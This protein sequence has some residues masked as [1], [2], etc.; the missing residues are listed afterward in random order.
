MLTYCA[1]SGVSAQTALDSFEVFLGHEIAEHDEGGILQLSHQSVGSAEGCAQACLT[2]KGCNSFEYGISGEAVGS[3]RLSYD[4]R[5]TTAA[6]EYVSTPLWNYY[7]LSTP[8][9]V[10]GAFL[11]PQN[12]TWLPGADD[13]ATYNNVT[14]QACAGLCLHNAACRRYGHPHRICA[15]S[16]P[17]AFPTICEFYLTQ[18]NN[19]FLNAGIRINLLI[20]FTQLRLFEQWSGVHRRES[21]WDC[22]QRTADNVP[23]IGDGVESVSTYLLWSNYSR[24]VSVVM[25]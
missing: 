15:S 5:A 20:F 14:K 24:E 8:V 12:N 17:C 19:Q 10:L 22:G 3:C 25:R 2:D 13:V 7:E 16:T 23:G 11:A 6:S 4:T 1:I 18:V 21:I 9:D